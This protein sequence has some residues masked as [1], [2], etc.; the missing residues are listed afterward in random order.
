MNRSTMANSWL[1]KRA[2]FAITITRRTTGLVAALEIF[3]S[4]LRSWLDDLVG[5][6]GLLGEHLDQLTVLVFGELQEVGFPLSALP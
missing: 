2:A 3:D 1:V 4:R 5:Q 6:V